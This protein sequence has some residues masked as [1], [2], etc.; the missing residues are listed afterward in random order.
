MV[1]SAKKPERAAVPAKHRKGFAWFEESAKDAREAARRDRRRAERNKG[2]ALSDEELDK[3]C[4]E[5][6]MLQRELNPRLNRAKEIGALL[7]AHWGHT[8]VAEIETMLGKTLIV[9]SF[10]YS[11]DPQVIRENVSEAKWVGITTRAIQPIYLLTL[12]AKDAIVRA[13]VGEALAA[14]LKLSV[15]PPSSRR[16]RSGET[17]EGEAPESEED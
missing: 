8:G 11:V 7:L 13:T 5:L 17:T 9:E 14:R 1:K 16:P 10:E 4:D 3:L 15:V 6:E 12:A 2:K